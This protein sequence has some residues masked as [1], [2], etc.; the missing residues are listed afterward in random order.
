MPKHKLI[1]KHQ[2]WRKNGK[3]NKSE[4]KKKIEASG[5]DIEMKEKWKKPQQQQQKQY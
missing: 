4:Q 2:H 1:E 5:H 3:K